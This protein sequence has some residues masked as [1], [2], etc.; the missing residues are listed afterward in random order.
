MR[1]WREAL[2]AL[3][4]APFDTGPDSVFVAYYASAELGCFLELGWPLPVNVLD[5]F[6]EHRVET[7]GL[8]LPCGN[9]LIGALAAR[10]I[11]HIDAGEKDAMRG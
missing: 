4:S 8:T 10:G 9:G 3:R 11:G 6:A 5:L 2:L 7:N 1:L